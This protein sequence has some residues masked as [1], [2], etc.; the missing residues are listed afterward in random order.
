MEISRRPAFVGRRGSWLGSVNW[1][2]LPGPTR[3]NISVILSKAHLRVIN[4]Q[5]HGHCY[6]KVTLGIPGSTQAFCQWP[7]SVD[8]MSWILK[9]WYSGKEVSKKVTG[10]GWGPRSVM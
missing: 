5:K 4:K 6:Q 8:E 3:S 10:H 1:K 2:L 9:C 7:R